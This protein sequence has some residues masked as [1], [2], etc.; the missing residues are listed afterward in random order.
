[1]LDE[2][3]VARAIL[4]QARGLGPEREQSGA[5]RD[6]FADAP[7]MPVAWGSRTLSM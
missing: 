7:S 4:G 3:A 6:Q 5:E 2:G 1:V